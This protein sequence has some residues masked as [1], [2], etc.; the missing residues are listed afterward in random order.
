MIELKPLLEDARGLEPLPQSA[1]RLAVQLLGEEWDIRE[2][3]DTV[4]LDQALT[5]RLLGAANSALSGARERVGTVE[6]ALM[7]L[8]A[9][10]V[11]GLALGSAVRKSYQTALPAYRLDEGDLWRHSVASALAV[12]EVKR[13]AT[14]TIPPE[15]FASALLHDVGKLVLARHLTP[16]VLAHLQKLQGEEVFGAR[17]ERAVLAIDHAAIGALVARSWG[18]PEAIATGI[19]HHER[20]LGARSDA[21]RLLAFLVGLSDAVAVRCGAPCG[22]PEPAPDFS[23]LHAEG[24]G[25]GAPAFEELCKAVAERLEEVLHR[26][27]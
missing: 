5:G 7:R 19:E 18:L 1:S 22:G 13:F 16:E 25:I 11:L 21:G 20:P 26:Y 12:E 10:A 3:C 8:G 6:D 15:A 14:R 2:V 24:V 27:E 9:G 23:L 17:V 4:R